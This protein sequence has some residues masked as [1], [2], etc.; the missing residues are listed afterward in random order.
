MKNLNDIFPSWRFTPVRDK[1]P[2][3]P[4]WANRPMPWNA[5]NFPQDGYGLLLG[6]PSGGVMALDFDGEEAFAFYHQ[7]FGTKIQETLAWASGKPDRTQMAFI[8]PEQHWGTLHTIKVSENKKLE[9]RWTGCQ[10][11]LPPSHHPETGSYDWVDG[12]DPD[13]LG[14]ATIPDNLLTF[15]LDQCRPVVKPATAITP[16]QW[17][18]TEQKTDTV[19]RLLEVI[20]RYIPRPDYDTWLKISFAVA[21]ELGV[22][23]ALRVL[24]TVWSEERVGE[25]RQLFQK[26]QD[27]VSPTLGTLAHI[28]R[29]Y[30]D[31]DFLKGRKNLSQAEQLAAENRQLAAKLRLKTRYY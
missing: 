22:G 23:E 1:R 8:V 24:P 15:W 7:H 30:E 2:Y 21:R 6:R 31:C 27:A 17:E 11:V 4:D 16:I 26:Y 9:F 10:S 3:L 12:Q 5:I 25:Y 14:V 13:S 19:M 18:N 29:Q 28:A 20:R